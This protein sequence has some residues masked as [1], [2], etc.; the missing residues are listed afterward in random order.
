MFRTIGAGSPRFAGLLSVLIAVCASLC[1]VTPSPAQKKTPEKT[2]KLAVPSVNEGLLPIK[3]AID[4][5]FFKAEGVSVELINFRGGG[6]A[7]QAFAGGGVDLCICAADHVVRLVNRRFD[8][9]IIVGLDEHHSYA[10]LGKAGASY[11]DVKS[12]KGKRIGVTSPGSLTDNTVRWA[13]SKTGLKP[14]RDFQ[15]VSAGGG[16]AMRA[17]IDS[18]QVDA[19]AV[20]STEV[21]DYLRSGKFKVVTDWR[22]LRYPALVV[23]GRQKWVDANNDEARRFVRAVARATRLVQTDSAAVARSAKVLYP[24]FSNEALAG[25][26][27]SA[28]ARL[29]KDGSVSAQGFEVMQEVVLLSDATL[30]RVK[31]AD[32]DLQ[33]SLSR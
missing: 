10:L 22:T 21:S 12:L 9:R 3:V 25:I 17:A 32:V 4:Q 27:A 5:G 23:I 26:A 28:K 11:G 1:L 29:S 20:V 14:E 19:G 8:A 30:T 16:A 2:L 24:T 33:P 13:I 6:P 31:Q 15:I 18:G 7:V